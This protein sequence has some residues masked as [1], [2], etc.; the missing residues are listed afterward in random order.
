[1][2]RYRLL[3]AAK[4]PGASTEVVLDISKLSKVTYNRL[5]KYFNS[6]PQTITFGYSSKTRTLI[7]LMCE[8]YGVFNVNTY[9]GRVQIDFH[10]AGVPQSE[11]TEF[12]PKLI[13]LCMADAVAYRMETT[14]DF[15]VKRL[16]EQKTHNSPVL[17]YSFSSDEACANFVNSQEFGEALNSLRIH[18]PKAL[19]VAKLIA[20]KEKIK[21]IEHGE[22]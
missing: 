21:L 3:E 7:E 4:L 19:Q 15:R 5:F 13:D 12:M 1:M 16:I 2:N 10:E 22:L 11:W 14:H 6:Y 8:K 17:I 18:V 9:G 20:N